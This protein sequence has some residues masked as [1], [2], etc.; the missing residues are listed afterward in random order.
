MTLYGRLR[1]V[2]FVGESSDSSDT[3]TT[4]DDRTTTAP[5]SSCRR[6]SNKSLH[7]TILASILTDIPEVDIRPL[8]EC[9]QHSKT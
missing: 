7:G 5:G 3:Y 6:Q 8:S 9:P 4:E 2:G 1:E